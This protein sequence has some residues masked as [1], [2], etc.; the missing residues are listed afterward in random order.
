MSLV[1]QKALRAYET[2]GVEIPQNV[3]RLLG[4]NASAPKIKSPPRRA[5]NWNA[6]R[7]GYYVRPGPGKQPYFY[8]VPVGKAA[9]KKTV[10]KAY[11]DAGVAVPQR[12]RNIFGITGNAGPVA[13]VSVKVSGNRI[14]G[15]QYSRYT[16][17][18]LVQMARN[19][20]I[21]GASENKTAAQIFAM[22][23]KKVGSSSPNS[24]ESPNV[25][26]NGKTYTFTNTNR[27]LRN[28]RARQ[29]NTLTRTERLAVAKAYMKNNYGNFE[30]RPSKTWY[31]T[32]KA[33]K[34]TR[35]PV[36]SPSPSFSFSLSPSSSSSSP[37][38]VNMPNF[39]GN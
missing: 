22:I 28:G 35:G 1:R 39:P 8:K 14:N 27:I 15:K 3:V 19:M 13:R 10:I 30:S 11:A 6:N 7:P 29:F 21:A 16:I 34:A 24:V 12:V 37:S 33:T 5:S 17:A 2:A 38:Y 20:N 31:A 32:L 23:K 18:Q 36:S 25:T 26:L 9:G 4:A